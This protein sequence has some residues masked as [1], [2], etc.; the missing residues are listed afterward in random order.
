[1][2]PTHKQLDHLLVRLAVLA[3]IAVVL[4]IEVLR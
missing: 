4:L 3:I 2:K 1:M